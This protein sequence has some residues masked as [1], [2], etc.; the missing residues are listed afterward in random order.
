MQK[1]SLAEYESARQYIRENGCGTV[2]PL[3]IAEKRQSGDI[4]SDNSSALFWHYSG[5][6]FIYG[7]LDEPFLDKVYDCF[8]SNKQKLSRRSILFVNDEKIK[9]HFLSK[10]GINIGKRY[11]Y[12]YRKAS[13]PDS[14]GPP[15]NMK[16]CE[17]SSE[18]F[19]KVQGKVT[20][21]FSWC[22]KNEFLKHGKG[23]CIS[24]GENAAAWAFSAAISSEEID[25]GIETKSEYRHSGL[26]KITAIRM[27]QYCFQQNKRPVWACDSNNTASQKLAE[28][29]GFEKTAECYT[30]RR[31]EP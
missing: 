24:D 11:F 23:Y 26:G 21:M 14:I 15:E 19:D 17:I 29:I 6:A 5:F 12:E 28:K 27:L 8:L 3:S 2:Y 22:S 7:G 10:D 1:L 20:P 31:T 25:I 9:D 30:V 4:F 13:A 16:L 18:L